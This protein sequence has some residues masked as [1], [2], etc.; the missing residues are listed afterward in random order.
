MLESRRRQQKHLKA[1]V[2]DLDTSVF[3]LIRDIRDVTE[4]DGLSVAQKVADIRALPDRG[5]T[6]AFDRLKDDLAAAGKDRSWFDILEAQSLRSRNRLSPILQ[7]ISFDRDGCAAQLTDAID[8]FKAQEGNVGTRAPADFLN[9][10]ERAALI[11]N[12]GTFRTSLYK[13]FLF[14]RIT[15]AIKSGDPISR[16]PASTGQ[17]TPT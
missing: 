17:W 8:H 13:V 9:N 12:N 4:A 7:A 3:G 2:D 1:V 11:R 14:Q 10:D 5:L 6:G 15:A 16:S